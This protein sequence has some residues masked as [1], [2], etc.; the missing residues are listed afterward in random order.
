MGE[1]APRGAGDVL[2][3][4]R[5]GTARTKAEL[6]GITGLSRGTLSSRVD[7]LLSA[8]LVKRASSA[9]S[10]GGRP[11]SRL[12]FN[13]LAG[14]VLAID[15]G[16]TH[17]SIAVTDLSAN[18]LASST[19]AVSISDGPEDVLGMLFR[20]GRALL[21]SNSS[22]R[23][24]G[25]GIG[26]PGPVEH[27][28][29][30]PISPPIMPGWD[31][32]DIPAL[33][34]AEFGVR[35]FIDNDVNVLALGERALV[36]PAVDE[37]VF[38]KVSTGVGAGI[39]SRGEIHRGAQGSA[40]DIG[41]VQVPRNSQS[42]R[43]LDDERDLEA[44]ASA[45]AIAASLRAEGVP[46][47]DGASVVEL[48]RAG[49]RTTITALRQAGRELGEVLATLVNI[50]NPSVLVLGG[51]LAG[52]GEHLLA[53]V[54]E[55]VYRRSIPLSTHDLRIV[56]SRAEDSAGMLGAAIMV[57]EQVLSPAAVDSFVKA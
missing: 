39:L 31:R 3:V 36:W 20:E 4:L 46:A 45:P 16:A 5:D 1:S 56:Q 53:G 6:C 7:S 49:D 47:V 32:F 17:A 52:A 34:H 10:S 13:P 50:V 8:N 37:L 11:A 30:L 2:S 21:E 23:L 54:R 51:S 57:I 14:C 22:L 33:V 18:I 48:A 12:V 27:T 9:T 38:V 41:H 35:G 55:V 26:I 25:V 24:A 29:G 40:G 15:L 19:M 42:A 43:P 44:L 28:T